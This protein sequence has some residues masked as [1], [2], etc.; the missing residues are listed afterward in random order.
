MIYINDITLPDV[1]FRTVRAFMEKEEGDPNRYKNTYVT[2]I[3][4]GS[5]G[6]DQ[7]GESKEAQYR[8][9][10]DLTVIEITQ[11]WVRPL[12]VRMPEGSN[13]PEV[14]TEE[15][16]EEYFANYLMHAYL[17]KNENYTYGSRLL[18]HP[19]MAMDPNVKVF[20]QVEWVIKHI[21]DSPQNNHCCLTIAMGGDL[22][23][24]HA[25]CL[26]L[27]DL[28]MVNGKLNMTLYFRSWDLYTGFPTNMGGLQLLNEYISSEVGCDPGSLFAVS[29]GLHIYSMYLDMCKTRLGW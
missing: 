25:P 7:E 13:M 18:A 5:Y 16:I 24:K 4:S 21:I 10:S 9:Q 20:N 3:D 1:W 12:A 8:V 28:K 6:K 19:T 27:L 15:K 11:P 2:E 14:A 22:N 26:R 17:Q 29:S 23:L